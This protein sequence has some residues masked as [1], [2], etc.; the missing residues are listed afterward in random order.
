MEFCL[1]VC[2]EIESV[3]CITWWLW[4]WWDYCWNGKQFIVLWILIL[5]FHECLKCFLW[6]EKKMLMEFFSMILRDIFVNFNFFWKFTIINETTLPS[7]DRIVQEIF[8][9]YTY[10]YI[11]IYPHSFFQS[12][13]PAHCSWIFFNFFYSMKH[14]TNSIQ[15]HFSYSNW[16]LFMIT[17]SFLLNLCR[18]NDD[19]LVIR[20]IRDLFWSMYLTS[21]SENQ[22]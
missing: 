11:Y 10:I 6:F 16:T 4:V 9:L 21:F 13:D 15:P 20:R 12:N 19:P 7:L 22:E 14:Q 18:S 17:L 5:L 3:V 8:T 2:L 1:Q